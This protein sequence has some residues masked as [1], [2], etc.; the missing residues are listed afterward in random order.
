MPLRAAPA[1]RAAAF[2]ICRKAGNEESP[3][4]TEKRC[5]LMAGGGDPRESATESEPPVNALRGQGAVRVKRWGKSPPRERQRKRHGKPH[6]EQDRI[7]TPR[8]GQPWQ[9][10]PV[11]SVRVGC[12]RKAATPFQDEW[13]PR[14]R[15]KSQAIQNPA[16]RPAGD[17]FFVAFQL[18]LLKYPDSRRNRR[19]FASKWHETNSSLPQFGKPKAAIGS[20]R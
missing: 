17:Y 12:V 8:L 18:F 10:F 6:R 15:R 9:T 4:S 20:R 14:L 19:S 16:Y 11:V 2:P 5:R 13:P 1:G 3:G 7:G